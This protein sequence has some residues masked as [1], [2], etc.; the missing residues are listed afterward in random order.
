MNGGLR[1]YWEL[2]ANTSQSSGEFGQSFRNEL[3]DV[4]QDLQVIAVRGK[5][6]EHQRFDANRQTLIKAYQ[7]TSGLGDATKNSQVMDAVA[8]VKQQT[9]AKA[10]S[11]KAGYEEWQKRADAFDAAVVK[12]A[13]LQDANHPKAA[14]LYKVTEAIQTRVNNGDF[15]NANT[16]FDQ[17]QPKLNDINDDQLAALLD[18]KN[19]PSDTGLGELES[20]QTQAITAGQIVGPATTVAK[21]VWNWINQQGETTIII[22]NR[23]SKVM[24]RLDGIED[25]QNKKDAKWI[26]KAPPSIAPKEKATLLIKTDKFWRGKTTANTSGWVGYEI[27]DEKGRHTVR[28]GWV[29]KGAGELDKKF[30][31]AEGRYQADGHQSNDGE[32]T[33]W[34]TEEASA[35]KTK[36]QPKIEEKKSTESDTPK[37]PKLKPFEYTIGPFVTGKHDKLESSSILDHANEIW[38]RK[39]SVEIREAI[40]QELPEGKLKIEVH[41]YT[42]NTDT[43]E[44]NFQ[45]SER[46]A[47][48]VIDALK[49]IGIPDTAFTKRQPHGEWEASPTDDKKQ[50]KE[51]SDWRKVVV[52]VS[53]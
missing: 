27:D 37:K 17:L 33:F 49:K 39:L 12:V 52:R 29:R 53:Q 10:T 3:A 7:A 5:Q 47:L 50:E 30:T 14:A 20:G 35:T 26:K 16:A 24:T 22:E 44:R 42:S 6:D 41:G 21:K 31:F 36:D 28:I 8:K 2:P 1:E 32:F 34:V 23:T 51:S 11:L 48:A 25:L 9:S 45:L 38:N 40:L 13:G 43:K 46:R 15:Q 4:N 18:P 19:N